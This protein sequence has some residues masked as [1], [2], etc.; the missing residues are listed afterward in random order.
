[1]TYNTPFFVHLTPFFRRTGLYE[2]RQVVALPTTPQTDRLGDVAPQ[3][4]GRNMRDL[5]F[6]L[7]QEHCSS[8]GQTGKKCFDSNT[9]MVQTP[10]DKALFK[11]SMVQSSKSQKNIETE[12]ASRRLAEIPS[13]AEARILW[14]QGC[15][16]ITHHQQRPIC[17]WPSV[18]S[19]N[20]MSVDVSQPWTTVPQVTTWAVQKQNFEDLTHLGPPV[21]GVFHVTGFIA[22]PSPPWPRP[23]PGCIAASPRQ[24]AARSAVRVACA[25]LP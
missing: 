9:Q 10:A 3:G 2:V 20:L 13:F 4:T 18:P 24:R 14:A 15:E 16:E 17:F 11:P 25:T 23:S 1:M 7:G 21:T 22:S 12:R 19:T 6:A 5:D 8:A